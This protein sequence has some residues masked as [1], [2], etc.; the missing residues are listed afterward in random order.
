MNHAMHTVT[1]SKNQFDQ[2]LSACIETMRDGSK[3][4]FAA[5]R[6]L[7]S[8]IRNPATALYAFCRITDDVA[9][10]ADATAQSIADLYVRLNQIY[11]GEPLDIPADRALAQVVKTFDIPK[12]LPLALIEGYEWDTEYRTYETYED[13]LDYCSRVAGTVG[14]MMCLIMGK[15]EPE[16]LARACEL[17]LAMQ[18]TNIAR[19]VGEDALNGRIYLP[20]TWLREAGLD[21][22]QWLTKP[23]FNDAI[24]VVVARLLKAADVLYKQAEMG[25]GD[26][27]WDCRPG[28]QAARLIYA[29]IG[30]KLE[31]HQL[32]SVAVRAVV[33]KQRKIILLTQAVSAIVSKFAMQ[34]EN[35]QAQRAIQYLLDAVAATPHIRHY[36]G[37]IYERLTWVVDLLERVEERRRQSEE[38]NS[39]NQLQAG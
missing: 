24:A 36:G 1:S 23:E 2:D 17:G 8:R 21:P 27:P 6:V 16:T 5:S 39:T 34:R 33:S 38:S 31:E 29:E 35:P 15:R 11:S 28:I 10:A 12:A 3:S 30:R 32:N 7:P 4:F 18:L 19:D 20:L 26:L 9:D 14:A 22:K 37:T 13:L 25:I